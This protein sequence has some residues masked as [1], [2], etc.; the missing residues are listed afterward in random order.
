M[1]E[2][3]WSNWSGSVRFR[4]AAVER[5]GTLDAV[6]QAVRRAAAEGWTVRVA[7]RGHSFTP[8]VATDGVL[9]SL[10]DAPPV[11]SVDR[12]RREADVPG[13]IRLRAL[14]EALSAEGLAMENLGDIDAQALAGALATGTHGTGRGLG[15][16]STQVA[17]LTLVT[18]DGEVLECSAEREPDVF[19]AAGV[20]LG[21]LGVLWRVRLRVVPAYRLRY[22]R[23]GMDLED[24]LSRLPEL[25]AS[26]HFELYW[27]PHT[28]RVDTKAMDV[29]EEPPSRDGL[30]R[31]LG[32]VVLENGAFWLLSEACRLFPRLTA[33][34]S[35]LAARLVS[36]GTRVGP[37]HRVFATPRL[38][39]FQE[40][41]YAVP[42]ERGPDCLREIRRHVAERRLRVH[43]PVEYR[44]VKGDD[45]WLSPAHGRDSVYVAVH[46]YRGMPHE[47]YFAGV[48]AIFRNHGGRP[49]WGKMHT[50]TAA[51]LAPLY[52]R[53][54]AFR[55][56][57]RR[58]DPRGVFL[59]PYLRTVL[60]A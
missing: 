54:E 30:A 3:R 13:G 24:C 19:R 15:T 1:P 10:E 37:S 9:L 44:F 17:G 42:A 35:R 39:R 46:Q 23:R 36:E 7:G 22:V 4:P 38:V 33:P 58:L 27:F 57:R 5:P 29:T 52:P 50:R 56:V 32:D 47:D 25:A 48:E 49:H 20:S 12:E 41:E 26:R 6:R 43:F 34:T 16:L 31:F 14:G 53:W 59:S 60:G 28:G 40:M 18:A 8:L 55:D 21:A 51:D 2:A 11:L 45:L